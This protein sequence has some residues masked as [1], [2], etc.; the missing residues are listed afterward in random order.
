MAKPIS[1]AILETTGLETITLAGAAPGFPRQR[2]CDLALREPG[3]QSPAVAFELSWGLEGR[4]LQVDSSV[5]DI[6]SLVATRRDDRC[7]ACFFVLGAPAADWE[8]PKDDGMG[9]LLALLGGEGAVE[10]AEL[11]GER[12]APDWWGRWHDHGDAGYEN[13]EP[14]PVP[15]RIELRE[16]ARATIEDPLG[17]E[18]WQ[19]RCV[20]V[21]P[22]QRSASLQELPALD[23]RLLE[24]A[25]ARIG[26][27]ERLAAAF[28]RAEEDGVYRY[29]HQSFKVFGLQSLVRAALALL[30][31]LTPAEEPLYHRFTAICREAL[32]H[33]W[34]W[35]EMQAVNANWQ[36]R[37]RPVL[38]AFW[39]CGYFLRQLA[40]YG[41]ELEAAPEMLPDGWA[42]VL[43]LYG[44]R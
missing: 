10:S 30:S 42:A 11:T 4:D 32:A 33:E 23:E 22:A 37:A 20:W 38:E 43:E 35:N 14:P 7:G 2:R 39:H 24:N 16:V 13:P 5:L 6:L 41:R 27:V 26:D 8:Q 17:G 19:L 44:Q 28:E 40:R 18:P 31:E 3:G 15:R 12:I 29:Y 21:I 36:E 9:R 34:R 25:K 1:D